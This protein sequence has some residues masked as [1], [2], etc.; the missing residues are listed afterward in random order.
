MN[1]TNQKQLE[2]NALAIRLGIVR[3]VAS[4]HGGHIGGSMDL[5]EVLAVLYS[6]FMRV[7]P[8]NPCWADRDFLIMSKGHAGP[9]LYSTLAWKG[10]FPYER[11]DNLNNP[12][13]L[14]PG[15]CDRLKV[16]GVD[17]TSG[18][19]G[20][21]LSIAAGAALAAKISGRDQRVFC[22]TGDGESAEGQIW[23]AAQFSAHYKLD[24]LITFMDW[25][26]MQID[27]SN[28][29]VMALGDPV[30]KYRSF[31]WNAKVVVGN[32]VLAIQQAVAD[33]IK[34]PNHMPTMI[35]LDTVKGQGAK[36]I[37]DMPNNHCIG[38]PESLH[39]QVMDELRQQGK[40][41]GMEVQ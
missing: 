37:M 19:L 31:G 8:K 18:S 41:L 28:D 13:S 4:N 11:L 2:R 14:L 20:Q 39:Q 10:F 24:N 16:P 26:K 12:N 6:D 17:A 33:A 7:N 21:G 40:K 27:G 35:V 25:N 23:E 5:A 30:N 15:H 1:L 36:C 22:I 38:F 3:A 32:D 9:A 34:N 29:A